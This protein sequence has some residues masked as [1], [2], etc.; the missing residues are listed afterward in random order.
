MI[1][2]TRRIVDGIWP[3]AKDL[4]LKV[5]KHDKQKLEQYFDSLRSVETKLEKSLNPPPKS[6][7]PPTSPDL[8]K[9]KNIA[10]PEKH[11]EYVRLMMDIM[12]LGM[13]TDTTR[14][15][16]LM[17]GVGISHFDYKFVRNGDKHHAASHHGGDPKRIDGYINIAKWIVEQSGYLMKRM[18]EIDEGNGSLLDNSLVLTG[19]NLSDGNVHDN[20]DV[21]VVLGGSAGGRIKTGRSI[22]PSG[23]NKLSDLMLSILH[24]FDIPMKDLNKT[25]SKVLSELV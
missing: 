8:N 3:Q 11:E 9:Y 22:T 25:N 6:W 21:P 10:I 17:Y 24:I 14:V 7:N 19:S 18:D 15:T 5:S 1:N 4:S 16:T 23:K 13:W 20:D 2:R 12:L